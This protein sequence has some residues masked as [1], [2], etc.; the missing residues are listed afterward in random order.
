M[1]NAGSPSR[2]VGST[3]GSLVSTDTSWAATRADQRS[4]AHLLDPHYDDISTDDPAATRPRDL[5]AP[6]VQLDPGDPARQSSAWERVESLLK[7]LGSDP[8]P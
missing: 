8:R 3:Y 2:L 7:D 1:C 6:L 5:L 4:H